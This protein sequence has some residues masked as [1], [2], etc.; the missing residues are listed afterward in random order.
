MKK[1]LI[2]E[3][4]KEISNMYKFVLENSY[5]EVEVEYN[6]LNWLAKAVEF[7]PDVIILDIMMPQTNWFEVLE[8][9]KKHSSL[10]C[11]IIVNS[12]LSSEKDERESIRLWAD[13]YLRKS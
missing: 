12:N 1:V 8:S 7:K 9:I 4:D 3:D 11:K 5:Y 6:W 10:D 13:K 2:I